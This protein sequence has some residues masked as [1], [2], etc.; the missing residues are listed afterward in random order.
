M[1]QRTDEW[2]KERLGHVTASKIKDV[3]AKKG[4]A[5]RGNYLMQLV[6]ERLTGQRE[7]TFVSAAMKRGIEVED[8]ARRFNWRRRCT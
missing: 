3:L 6:S 1:E 4:T 7:E 8:K 5:T 2:F